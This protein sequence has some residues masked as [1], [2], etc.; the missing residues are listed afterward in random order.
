MT[1]CMTPFSFIE[2][3]SPFNLSGSNTSLGWNLPGII[4][5]IFS[6]TA[7]LFPDR[8]GISSGI[9]ALSPLH[10]ALFSIG[11]LLF[12]LSVQFDRE[13]CFQEFLR[14]L[15]IAACAL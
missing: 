5:L 6:W 8:R 15:I 1:G 2:S 4:S 14:E 7:P 11:D 10:N 12:L 9:K 13:I 3:A